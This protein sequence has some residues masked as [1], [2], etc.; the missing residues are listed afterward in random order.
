MSPNPVVRPSNRSI[1]A[2]GEPD[3]GKT[4]DPAAKKTFNRAFRMR[5]DFVRNIFSDLGFSGD[6]LEM[7]A[8]LFLGYLAWEYTGFYQQSKA[9]QNRLLKFRLRLFTEK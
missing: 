5:L 1:G 9:K 3:G 4:S 2:I 7:R 6:E 8:Q